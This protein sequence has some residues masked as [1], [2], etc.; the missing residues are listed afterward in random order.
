MIELTKLNGNPVLIN[1]AQIE[2][3]DLIPEC[4]IIMLNGKYHIVKETKEEIMEKVIG[5][6]RQC[7]SRCLQDREG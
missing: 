1:S 7:M 2:Y 3:I 4:K 5:F 6:N